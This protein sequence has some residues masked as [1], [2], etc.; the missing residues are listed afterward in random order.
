MGGRYQPE[1][2]T[3][4]ECAPNF[5]VPKM[6]RSSSLN[7]LGSP[8]TPNEKA[9]RSAFPY[10]PSSHYTPGP[11]AYTQF[12]SFGCASGP[13]RTVYFGTSKGCAKEKA[14]PKKDRER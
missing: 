9:M 6:I 7:S 4:Q 1:N 2:S 14:S 11:G 8:G 10:L 12:S 5:S 3:T 13:T